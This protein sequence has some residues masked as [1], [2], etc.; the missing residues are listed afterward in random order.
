MSDMLLAKP[1]LDADWIDLSVGEA[2]VVRE[3]FLSTFDWLTHMELSAPHMYEY[4]LPTGYSPL[5]KLLED[6]Y[7]APVI[8]TN[9]AKNALGAVFHALKRMG[10]KHVGMKSPHWTLLPPLL[11][12]HGLTWSPTLSTDNGVDSWLLVAPGNPD[13]W[14]PPDMEMCELVADENDVPLIH[15]GVY[16]NHVYLPPDHHLSV[17]GDVQIHSASKLFGLSGLR[18]GWAVCPNPDFY[19]YMQ[20]YME[21]MTVGVSVL[22]QL[23][24]YNIFSRMETCPKLVEQFE[25]KARDALTANK[26]LF[27]QV[28]PEVLELPSNLQD[29]P[30][31]FIFAKVMPKC[32]FEKA[33]LNVIDGEHFGA[34]GMVRINAAIDPAT[35][36]EVVNRLNGA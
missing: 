1:I 35:M 15:D 3:A 22:P 10:K 26:L 34:P 2:H 32:D 36:T 31:M 14:M 4:P 13:G 6:K 5:V 27:S 20:E 30:G 21:A 29:I 12:M 8:I 28:S 16:Y 11:K 19:K 24:I 23:F 9:G 18:L 25:A 33:K 17:I 7:Q